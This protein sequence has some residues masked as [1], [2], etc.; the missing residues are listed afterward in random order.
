LRNITFPVEEVE[1][2][3]PSRDGIPALTNPEFLT[4]DQVDYMVDEDV[5]VAVTSGDETRGYPVRI[6]NWHEV[7][8]D[9]IGDDSFVVTY[10]PLCG[11]AV[12]IEAEINGLKRNFG[13]SGMLHLNNVLMFDRET[14][15]L[16]SQFMLR[17]VSGS[18]KNT[19]MTW[20]LSE[21]IT[22]ADFKDKYPE[23]K[24]LSTDTGFIRPYL[25]NPYA[26]YND[27]PRPFYYTQNPIRDDLPIKDWVWGILIGDV[28]KAYSVAL[29]PDGAPIRDFVNGVELELVA[30]QAARSVEVTVVSS[31]EPLDN[32]MGAFWFAWQD[33]FRET[34]VF[35]LN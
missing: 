19:P 22:W 13:V 28:A 5:L 26:R 2:E 12:V 23:G 11:S 15:S 4:L 32:G 30:N 27:H 24:L 8:N 31:G 16:W 29:L 17:S 35:L 34:L 21:Q 7:V 33:F 9:Q 3:G 25:E 20:K 1:A 6:L 14:E 10:C 18:M